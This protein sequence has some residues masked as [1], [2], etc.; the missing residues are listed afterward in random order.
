MA[1]SNDSRAIQIFAQAWNSGYDDAIA[2]VIEFLYSLSDMSNS[3]SDKQLIDSIIANF[4]S[5]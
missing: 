1:D 4:E 2:E 5:N 3:F